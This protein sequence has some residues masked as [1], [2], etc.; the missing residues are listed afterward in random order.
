MAEEQLP[1]V[2]GLGL[3]EIPQFEKAEARVQT[4]QILTEQRDFYAGLANSWEGFYQEGNIARRILLGI[5]KFFGEDKFGALEVGKKRD[6]FGKALE[7]LEED[8]TLA[9]RAL[10]E[11]ALERLSVA[12]F[13]SRRLEMITGGQSLLPS[14]ERE[15]DDLLSSRRHN[16]SVA[17]Q[18]IGLAEG[19]CK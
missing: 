7:K 13:D 11:L 19:I 14:Y 9:S 12:H 8:P 1:V 6:K 18:Y 16:L 3:V 5:G 15:P 17:A 4:G 2:T 10:S